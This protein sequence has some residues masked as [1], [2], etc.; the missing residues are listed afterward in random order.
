[1]VTNM[2]LPGWDVPDGLNRSPG[3]RPRDLGLARRTRLPAVYPL[4]YSDR[5]AVIPTFVL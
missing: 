1:M 4:A 3:N 2:L 5:S